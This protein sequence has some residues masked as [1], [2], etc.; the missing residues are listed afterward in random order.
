[1]PFDYCRI[2]YPWRTQGKVM[3]TVGLPWGMDAG[4]TFQSNP[5]PEINAN[6]AVTSAQ[7]Q[8]V[9]APRTTLNAGSATVG[10]I[11][12]GTDFGDRIYQ[13]DLRVSKSFSVRG[14]RIRAIADFGNVLNSST[15]LLQNNT[16]GTNWLRPSYI[17]PG[18]LFKP[19]VEV[20]F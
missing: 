12:P 3:G 9:S 18:R 4:A 1:M 8:F 17:M 10:L 2:E 16:Y 7:V 14:A 5:G 11:R 13:L 6:F 15:V 19:T 20:S